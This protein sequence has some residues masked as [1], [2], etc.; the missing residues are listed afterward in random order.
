MTYPDKKD[1]KDGPGLP[2]ENPGFNGSPLH[3]G[4]NNLFGK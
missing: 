1:P 2:L 3:K 4:P